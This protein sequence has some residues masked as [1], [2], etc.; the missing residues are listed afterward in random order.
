MDSLKRCRIFQNSLMS[1]LLAGDFEGHMSVS[2]ILKK[3]DFG[4]GTFEGLDGEMIILK[5]EAYKMTSDGKA[6]QAEGDEL[7][8]FAAVTEFFPF[9]QAHFK[10][11]ENFKDKALSALPSANYPYAIHI[12]GKFEAVA[13]RTVSKQRRPW[14]RMREATRLQAEREFRDVE[15]E[16]AGFW[17]PEAFAG[18][19][20]PGF[21]LHF[22]SRDRLQ[23]G[24]VLS[25]ELRSA[26][27]DF[28]FC[29]DL[30]FSLP[31][32]SLFKGSDLCPADLLLQIKHAENG[33]DS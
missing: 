15:G 32:G 27:A 18:P 31:S 22:I 30:S 10:R 19:C 26:K 1:A 24:H 9:L 20:V 23:G 33:A 17:M 6:R 14:K 7:S 12:S 3:G 25:M 21:H 28:A 2:Q 16:V 8:P 11:G 4:L 13:T 29:P 5:G